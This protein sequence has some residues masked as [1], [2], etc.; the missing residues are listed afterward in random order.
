MRECILASASPRRKEILEHLGVQLEVFPADVDESTDESDPE[1]LAEELS[2]RKGRTARRLLLCAGRDLT[3]RVLIASDTTVSV[4]SEILGKPRDE[5]DARRMLHLL[6]GRT[7]RVV[8]GI[9]LSFNGQEALS[10]AVTEVEL[11]PMSDCEVEAYLRTG[12]PYGKAGAYAIQG[13]AALWVRA[14]HGDYYNVVGLPINRMYE[15]F[16]EKFGENFL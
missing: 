11:A 4:G 2:A 12:E 6:R 13:I 14:I 3:D 8:S 9:Y 16:A 10:H 5:A 15:L 1:R 7:H